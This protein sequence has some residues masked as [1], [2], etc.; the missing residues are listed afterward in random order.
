[1]HRDFKRNFCKRCFNCWM[2][3]ESGKNDISIKIQ[4]EFK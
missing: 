2:A 3:P 1:M 4:K